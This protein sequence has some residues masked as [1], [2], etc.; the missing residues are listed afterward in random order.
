P[1]T[2]A[3]EPDVNPVLDQ[4]DGPGVNFDYYASM[5]L[6]GY[7]NSSLGMYGIEDNLGAPTGVSP[8]PPQYIT[9][10]SGSG[11]PYAEPQPDP[12]GY[13]TDAVRAMVPSATLTSA[14]IDFNGNATNTRTGSNYLSENVNLPKTAATVTATDKTNAVLTPDGETT[15]FIN[16]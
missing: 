5:S 7:N 2:P 3:T 15:W 16:S 1:P 12:I 4:V 11:T 6:L 8:P 10:Y 14:Q 13:Y 9:P